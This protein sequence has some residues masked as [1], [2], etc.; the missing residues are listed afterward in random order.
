MHSGPWG[1]GR[2]P[3]GRRGGQ[4]RSA[5]GRA[6][7][8]RGS[9]VAHHEWTEPPLALEEIQLAGVDPVDLAAPSALPHLERVMISAASRKEPGSRLDL[10][11][12]AD[13]PQL[14]VALF[15]GFEECVNADVLRRMPNLLIGG[16][17]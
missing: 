5:S 11:P 15:S 17:S 8:R 10:A 4:S 3:R 14:E 13:C 6:G 1:A 2:G 9:R 16:T 12:L 7:P